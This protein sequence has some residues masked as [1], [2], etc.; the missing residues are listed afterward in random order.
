MTLTATTGRLLTR[1][2]PT[3]LDK[4]RRAADKAGV[5]VAEYVRERLA[6]RIVGGHR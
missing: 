4:A 2:S 5:S 6:R 1:M 3:Q